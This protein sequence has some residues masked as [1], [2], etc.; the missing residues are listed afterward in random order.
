MN[1]KFSIVLGALALIIFANAAHSQ[2]CV[3]IK[4]SGASCMISHPEES[5]KSGW[6][7]TSGVRYFK[8]FRHFSGEIENTDRLKQGTEVINHVYAVDLSLTRI[9]NDRWSLMVDVP[10]TSNA[11]S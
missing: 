10:I 8:S 1:Q 4:G 2:G 11:R 5:N 9:L 3:A 7:F 6:L